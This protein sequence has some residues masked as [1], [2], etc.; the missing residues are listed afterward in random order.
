MRG[1][2]ANDH[3]FRGI[4]N[5]F[6]IDD[7]FSPH[8]AQSRTCVISDQ[9][10]GNPPKHGMSTGEPTNLANVNTPRR[11][12]G[13]PPRCLSRLGSD[14]HLVAHQLQPLAHEFFVGEGP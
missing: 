9:L 6:L 1:A 14:Y 12:H 2:V 3:S 7:A 11:L 13:R 4:Q 10:V 5:L 8:A